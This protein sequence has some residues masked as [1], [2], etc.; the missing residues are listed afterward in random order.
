YG[1]DKTYNIEVR[2]VPELEFSADQLDFG[3]VTSGG[4][5]PPNQNLTLTS[6][7]VVTWTT[8]IEDSWL[9]V[10]PI[11]DT[12]PSTAAVSVNIAGLAPGLYESGITFGWANLCS[13]TVTVT[14]QVNTSAGLNLDIASLTNGLNQNGRSSAT[15]SH[16][17]NPYAASMAKRP[18]LLQSEVAFV[19]VVELKESL[20]PTP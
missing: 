19:I 17:T 10:S 11:T 4:A 9:S 8:N 20:P 6:T 1:P 15:T 5:N 16:P 2:E 13:R 3:P 12:T 7:D 14:L 18:F